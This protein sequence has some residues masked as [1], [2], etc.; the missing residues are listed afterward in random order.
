MTLQDIV[1]L[2]EYNRWAN[3]RTLEAAE[4]LDAAALLK[5]LGN[6]FPS[7]RDTLAHILGAEWIW[8]RRWLGETPAKILAAAEFPTVASLREHFRAVDRERA[9]FLASVTEARLQQSFDYRDLAG[10]A[11]R[12]PLAQS[13]QHVV[14]HGTYHRGQ[15]TTM[16]R[17]LRAA[18]IG[19]DMSR[20]Y[21]D[22]AAGK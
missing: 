6:S 19:T 11:L 1:T 10:N 22:R 8:L 18:P 21:L 9:E 13:L 3:G 7:V 15:V 20:F 16:L 17:Q 12:L 5:D 4:R 2:Y 14:N